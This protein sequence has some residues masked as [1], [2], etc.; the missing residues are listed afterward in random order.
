[1]FGFGR[2]YK[3]IAVA[4]MNLKYAGYGNIPVAF[5]FEISEDKASKRRVVL[6]NGVSHWQDEV[7]AFTPVWYWLQGGP[8]PR[9]AVIVPHV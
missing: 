7:E 1:M 8:L 9:E 3:K 2:K 6:A 4:T 5:T